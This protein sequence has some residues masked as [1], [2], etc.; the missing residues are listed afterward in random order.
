MEKEKQRK[1]TQNTLGIF[2]FIS[3]SEMYYYS[4]IYLVLIV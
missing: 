1:K 3:K 2:P 4:A